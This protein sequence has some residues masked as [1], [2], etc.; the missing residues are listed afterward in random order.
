MY[1]T[2]DYGKRRE[3]IENPSVQAGFLPP[4]PE[5]GVWQNALPV[6]PLSTAGGICVGYAPESVDKDKLYNQLLPAAICFIVMSVVFSLLGL[7]GIF[8]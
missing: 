3:N 1:L 4:P 2:I 5:S 7:F 8:G 6:F